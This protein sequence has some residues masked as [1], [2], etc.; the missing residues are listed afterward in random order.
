MPNL[1]VLINAHEQVGN[2]G[3][4]RKVTSQPEGCAH[5]CITLPRTP[6]GLLN[7]GRGG[8]WMET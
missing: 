2:W 7:I 8:T 3:G 5:A 1:Q 4:L 6:Y